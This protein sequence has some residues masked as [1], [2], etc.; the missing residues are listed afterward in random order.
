MKYSDRSEE[1]FLLTTDINMLTE[2]SLTRLLSVSACFI[3]PQSSVMFITWC[4][5]SSKL[6]WPEKYPVSW[7]TWSSLKMPPLGRMSMVPAGHNWSRQAH[8]WSVTPAH[9][10][11]QSWLSPLERPHTL[12]SGAGSSALQSQPIRA[13]HTTSRYTGVFVTS[14]P[15]GH[16][17]TWRRKL[18]YFPE[19]STWLTAMI[20][21]MFI[22]AHAGAIRTIWTIFLWCVAIS[23]SFRGITGCPHH[24]CTD[25]GP[26]I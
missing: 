8:I 15:I 2:S 3:W 18:V 10:S 24:H 26:N 9:S 6:G 4:Q 22:V 14:L 12:D 25:W 21:L 23:H 19:V 17:H 1:L 16:H 7:T 13:P 20:S 5:S 11:S